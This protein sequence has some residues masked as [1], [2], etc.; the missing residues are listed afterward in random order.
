MTLIQPFALKRLCAVLFLG[1][2]VSGPALAGDDDR[3]DHGDRHGNRN[4]DISLTYECQD[5][6]QRDLNEC[7]LAAADAKTTCK[8]LCVEGDHSCSKACR[9]EFRDAG[10]ACETAAFECRV[11]LDPDLDST[12][13]AACLDERTA[14]VD[15]QATCSDACAD[16]TAAAI[17]ACSAEVSWSTKKVHRCERHAHSGRKDV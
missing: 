6:C 14:C 4:G 5:E 13:S 8:A 11:A 17:L 7:Q 16:Q 3:D 10:S 1:A 15:E 9:T 2:L 12:C